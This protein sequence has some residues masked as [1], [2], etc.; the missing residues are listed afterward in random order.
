MTQISLRNPR[1]LICV[2]KPL[3]LLLIPPSLQS[4][5]PVNFFF[6]GERHTPPCFRQF[7]DI[8]A[9]EKSMAHLDYRKVLQL[10]LSMMVGLLFL[11]AAHFS[12]RA[13]QV[14]TQTFVIPASDGYGIAECLLPGASCGQTLADAWCEAHGLDKSLAF[15]PA[16][17]ITAS[18]GAE[19]AP[20]AAPGSFIVSCRE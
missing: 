7:D 6:S 9:E 5:P 16:E 14:K 13:D 11:M 19:D 18:T 3:T 4:L 1:K 17:D 15:G 8:P 10:L 12:A 20:Q 2:A